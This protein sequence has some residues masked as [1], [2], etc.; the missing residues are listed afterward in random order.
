MISNHIFFHSV[1]LKTVPEINGEE[2]KNLTKITWS[3]GTNSQ[4]LLKEVLACKNLQNSFLHKQIT[5]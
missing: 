1:I 4:K 5:A 2:M 3:H